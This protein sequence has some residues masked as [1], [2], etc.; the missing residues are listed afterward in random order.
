M[1]HIPV[2][3]ENDFNDSVMS[4]LRFHLVSRKRYYRE[5]SCFS[6]KFSCLN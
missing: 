4:V 5:L 3:K 2:T 6:F 1:Q